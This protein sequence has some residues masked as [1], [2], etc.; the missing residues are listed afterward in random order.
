VLAA[1]LAAGTIGFGGTGAEGSAASGAQAAA[2][3]DRLRAVS[4]DPAD[5]LADNPDASALARR[6][7]A[8]FAAN[9][10]NAIYVNA[11]NVEYGAYYR[12][13]YPLNSESE[14]GRQD[15]L[16]KLVAAAHARGIA[17][18]A[19]FYDH[20]HR[21]A[22]EAHSEWRAKTEEGGDYNPPVTDIQ[23]YLSTGH[24]A[25]IAW[26]RG[27]L[28]DVLRRYPNLD[29]VELR[30]PIVTWWGTTADHNP[31]VTRAFRR[32]FPGEEIGSEAW[33]LHRSRTLTRF[34]Q[35]EIRLIREQGRLV[36]VTTVADFDADGVV[37]SVAAQGRETGFD[38]DGLLSGP[39]RPDAV[40]VELIWQQWA[41]LYGRIAFTPEWTRR[42]FAAF[43][44]QVDGRA[45][46]AV[47]VELTD[48]GRSVQTVEEFLRALRAADA[49]GAI[50]IDFYS[51]SLADTKDA[52][53]AVR[54]AYRS[55]S[56]PQHPTGVRRDRRVLVLG[57]EPASA[58]TAAQVAA[59][60]R[61]EL[62]NLIGHTGLAWEARPVRA[63]RRG[64]LEGFDAVVY[65]GTVYGGVPAAF[66]TDV[67]VFDGR[68]V[69]IG[70]N[71]FELGAAGVDLP[72]E[73]P[74]Q[75]PV[76][77]SG[78]VRYH[79]RSLAARGEL[80]PTRAGAGVD[81]V[82]T[83]TGPWGRL[84]YILRSGRLWYVTG[85][86]FSFLETASVLNGRYLVF[87]DALHDML[88]ASHAG[89]RR[90]AYVRIE[91]VN[92]LTDPARVR[93]LVAALRERHAPFL[94]GVSPFYEDPAKGVSVPLSDRPELVE[95]LHEAVATGGAIVLHGSTH[96][97]HGRTGLD[98]EFWDV[99]NGGGVVEDG[100]AYVRPRVEAALRELWD[101][102][103]HPIAWETPHY[104]A[105]PFDYSVL[106]D[107]FSTFV[108]RRTYGVVA[109]SAHQQP[110]P[111]TIEADVH[112]GRIVPENLGYVHA[113]TVDAATLARN[114]AALTI[115]RD[116]T[117]G[118]YVH[119][120]TDA[121][122]VG[123]LVDELRRL[124]YELAD[125]Y[126]VA[127]VVETTERVELTGGGTAS[128]PVATGASLER[129][130]LARDGTVAASS[131]TTYTSY[132]RPIVRFPEAAALVSVEVLS[133]E[134]LA[135][136]GVDDGG[137]SLG[138]VEDGL[139]GA[140]VVAGALGIVV[141][142]AVSVAAHVGGRR[143]VGR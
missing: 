22:W 81:V 125:L 103:L 118:G 69:W 41:R 11:Y 75:R 72:L 117:A 48:F 79:G 8:Q 1:L 89:E 140:L 80:I 121:A 95:A 37:L 51:A 43:A 143:M 61:A 31:A 38:L 54:A 86:P 63:Y 106:S 131:L 27:F 33:R 128:L 6:L 2:A 46:V 67:S 129:R 32:A 78:T 13:A 120:M 97:Y 12:T 139:L 17:V 130:V 113:G 122:I 111:Y 126:D 3:G 105:T 66:L 83:V 94:V 135:A 58:G 53:P 64:D 137:W 115:V 68:V 110:L 133:P 19:A 44:R 74:S 132:G 109:G 108:E 82:A 134:A 35:A 23:Y 7:V 112:G 36:H 142:V 56:S 127:N 49:P 84:P 85:S 107:Y 5:Y 77:G 92:P 20:Q 136:R 42:A 39:A 34:L 28:L 45:P 14:Y 16:G 50:G 10:V 18:F 76:T 21:G 47:H 104:L 60:Q 87:A 93:A 57:D 123:G 98:A 25:V 102:D 138:A 40:K 24:P 119:V 124:G 29:G 71:L 9:G 62:L 91:D 4:I 96:Q 70:Q 141:L 15:L 116:A 114:A 90:T 100:E 26:W 59:L 30:E 52:W 88:G 65:L 55:G 99:A 73:Q 101:V